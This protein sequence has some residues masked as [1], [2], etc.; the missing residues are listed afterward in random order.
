MN[1]FKIDFLESVDDTSIL[2]ELKR[3]ASS[4]KKDT[5]TKADIEKTGRVSYSLINKRFGSLRRALQQAGLVPTRFMNS[6]NGE[7]FEL[8]IDLWQKTL[9]NEGRRPY[10]IDLKKYGYPVSG[11][12]I[13][14]R[15][16]TWK[17]A[18]LAANN[19][20]SSSSDDI[21]SP[22]KDEPSDLQLQPSKS[23][24]RQ[25]L[26]LRKRFFVL[27][28]DQFT[29]RNCGK[30]GIG[31]R[32]EVDHKVSVKNGGTDALDNLVTLCFECNR[33]KR[34]DSQ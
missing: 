20:V 7:L 16:G 4:K 27:K 33:G 11:D 26:S 30:S 1:K 8:L 14:R 24:H 5:V 6:N 19:S 22:K 25:P 18:L 34:G 10:R 2:E 9:A 32:L 3:I 15:F 23:K 31:V 13:V 12:T 17:K 21:E 29:C 28:R